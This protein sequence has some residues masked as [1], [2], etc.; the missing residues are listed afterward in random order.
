[1]TFFGGLGATFTAFGGFGGAIF[2][3]DVTEGG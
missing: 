2:F 3:V 1:L